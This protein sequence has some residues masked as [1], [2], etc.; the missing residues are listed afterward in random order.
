M[1]TTVTVGSSGGVTSS[2]REARGRRRRARHVA[3]LLG[4]TRR[5]RAWRVELW[6]LAE[7]L[8]EVPFQLIHR[9]QNLLPQGPQMFFLKLMARWTRRLF[10]GIIPCRLS[11]C[12]LSR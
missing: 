11:S 9:L 1:V 2:G 5:A 6:G 3:F 4:K 7:K 10:A 8:R 12:G